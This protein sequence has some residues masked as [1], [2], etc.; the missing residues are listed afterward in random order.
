MDLSEFSAD[1]QF[2]DDDVMV[3]L[4]GPW[5]LL[6]VVAS[7]AEWQSLAKVKDANW[8][9]RSSVRLGTTNGSPAWWSVADGRLTIS[10]G[11]D[12]E[13]SNVFISMPAPSLDCIAHALAGL[14]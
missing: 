11:P 3:T 5:W 14:D 7:R 9:R 10:V 12:D 8:N 6:N 2:M 4:T 1:A 13:T